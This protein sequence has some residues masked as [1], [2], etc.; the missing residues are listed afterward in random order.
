MGALA[1]TAPPFRWP[2]TSTGCATSW[3]ASC[4]R[5]RTTW[6][7]CPEDIQRIEIGNYRAL[8]IHG[9]EIGRNGFASRNTIVQHCNRWRAGAYPWEFRDVYVGH[10]PTFTARSRWPMARARSTRPAQQVGQPL[11]RG[12]SRGICRP[13]PTP[14]LHR[15]RARAAWRPSSKCGWRGNRNSASGPRTPQPRRCSGLRQQPGPQG[16]TAL[17][18]TCSS[19]VALDERERAAVSW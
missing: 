5:A 7:D 19:G 16:A 3:L 10:L 4:S 18:P 11:R 9:D 17:A 12:E 13:V 2:T 15:P 1:P 8:L 6:D 14:A